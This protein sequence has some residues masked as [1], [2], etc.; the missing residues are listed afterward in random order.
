MTQRLSTHRFFQ[1]SSLVDTCES[2]ARINFR[3]AKRADSIK[4][5]S[6]AAYFR[7]AATKNLRVAQI[8]ALHAEL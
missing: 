8:A 6:A 5:R 2:N 1:L 4:N 3:C 7:A